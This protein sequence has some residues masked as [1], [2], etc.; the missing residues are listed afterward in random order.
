MRVYMVLR[1]P[2]V[3]ISWV[4]YTACFLSGVAPGLDT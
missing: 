1:Q 2:K 4:A 3:Y